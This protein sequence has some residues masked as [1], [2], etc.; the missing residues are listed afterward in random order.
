MNSAAIVITVATQ[1]IGG[2]KGV[3]AQNIVHL[4][5]SDVLGHRSCSTG[6][7]KNQSIITAVLQGSM[8]IKAAAGHFEVSE[9]WVKELVRRYRYENEAAYQSRSKRPETSLNAT[10]P[11]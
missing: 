9:R 3:W 2:G 6:E 11:P 7:N 1:D 10:P 4:K 8:S 5:A